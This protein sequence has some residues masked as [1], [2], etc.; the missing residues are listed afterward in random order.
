MKLSAISQICRKALTDLRHN[1]LYLNTLLSLAL[2]AALGAAIWFY[3]P[4]VSF[5][6]HSPLV[7]PEKR[8]YALIAL[9][10]LWLLKFLLIDMDISNPHLRDAE[11]RKHIEALINRFRGASEFMK[12]TTITRD[13]KVISLQQLPCFI[14]IGAA[15]AGKTAML[16]HS[17]IPFILQRHFIPSVP[18]H[19]EP[20]ENCDWWLTRE[21]GM[22]DVPSK[23]LFGSTNNKNEKKGLHRWL[24]KCFLSQI[25]KHGGKKQ[26][27]G[28]AL[29]IPF[30]EIMEQDDPEKLSTLILVLAKHIR[31]IEQSLQK[32]LPC[33]II[34]TKADLL[35]GFNEFFAESSEDETGQVWGIKLQP[36]HEIDETTQQFTRRFNA[37]IK[38]LNEQLLWRLHHER[39]PMA[40]PQIKDFPLEMEKLKSAVLKF[41]T[42]LNNPRIQSVYLTS[43]IQ[44]KPEP[45][46]IVIE[47]DVNYDH[48]AVQVFQDPAAKSRAYFIKQLMAEALFPK[49]EVVIPIQQGR[50]IKH[51]TAYAA[52]VLTITAACVILGRDFN[53]GLQKTQ[54]IQTNIVAYRNILRQFQNPNESMMKTLVLLESLQKSTE[55][56]ENK[57]IFSRLLTYYSDKTQK[58]AAIVYQHALQAFL[59]PEVRNYLADFLTRPVN[60]EPENI[61]RALKAYLMLGDTSAFDAGY[62][63]DTLTSI[64]PE[65]FTG[66]PIL[67]HHFDV[68]AQQFQPV[69]LN[70]K[71]I[72]NT[73]KYLLA[74]RGVQLG[75]IILKSFDSNTQNSDVLLNN[76]TEEN[77]LFSKSAME[78]PISAMFTGR[79]FMTVFERQTQMAAH[80][81]ATGNWVLGTGYHVSANPTYTAEL[82]EALRMEYVKNYTNTWENAIERIRLQKPNDL[83]QA[84]AMITSL[85]SYDSPLIKL[86]NI[87]HENTYF[88]PVSTNSIKLQ[89]IGQ[90]VDKNNAS[91]AELYALLSNLQGLHDYVQPVLNAENPRKA[92]YDLIAERMHHQGEPDPITKLR[93][94]ADQSPTPIKS[95]INQLSNDTWHFLLKNAMRYMDTSWAEDVAAPFQ[96]QIANRYPFATDATDEV[97]LKK[98]VSFFGK[99]GN[100]VSY[101]NNF[102]APFVDTS[103]A[104]WAWKQLDG[105]PL[106]FSPD[107][108]HQIQQALSI[109]HA[110]FPNDDDNLSVPFELRQHKLAAK[111]NRVKF[112]INNKVIVDKPASTSSPYVIA[113][114]HDV[115]G[116][117]TSVEVS[118]ADKKTQLTEF[119]GAWGWFK[120]VNKSYVS[121]PSKQEIMLNFSEKASP[122]EY[123]LSTQNKQNPF[124]ALNMNKFNLATQLTT[125]DS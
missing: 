113:W 38:K 102:L 55:A 71:T 4:D 48:R 90:M 107:V 45:E 91:K 87:V 21:G 35:P 79:Y 86:L 47:N 69:P 41:I 100:I 8:L 13:G 114:P 88:A 73:R 20:S 6:Q 84:D 97:P 61:Y 11:V 94:A 46:T 26:I 57:N 43:A 125:M 83:Q 92:A 51:Y 33:H 53:V 96:S 81:A 34:I 9:S 76:N 85:T 70:E 19:F 108:L 29:A 82:T 27:A 110:F 103:K 64:L 74:L 66:T 123:L 80:E 42:Q 121:A 28:I 122:A 24:W 1:K 65:K 49:R 78:E 30:A 62:V 14:L 60:Q 16:A 7:Q 72:I 95:W 112:N 50:N 116:N 39:N 15:G 12:K 56:E 75:Y 2:L 52:S 93:L 54:Q 68:A 3:G 111:L 89:A 25:K 104:E 119:A 18:E 118:L 101:Y 58:N 31:S 44:V 63:R 40:R 36:C 59:M 22:I 115:D 32:K 77:L 23:Y 124:L 117:L 17:R 120:L 67:L 105:Q 10:L 98:F 106:P 109:H 99:P 37:L 5:H